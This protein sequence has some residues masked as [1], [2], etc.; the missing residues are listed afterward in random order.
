MPELLLELLSEEIPARMQARAAEDLKRLVCDGLKDA[1]LSFDHAESYVTPRR[2]ALVVDGIPEKLAAKSEEIRGP[3]A[4]APEK[5]VAGFKG[6]LPEGTIIVK[7]ET[8]K[9]E[10]FFALVEQKGK[11]TEYVLKDILGS[12]LN[13]FPWPKSMKWAEC[14]LPW[15]RPL[16][17]ALAIF[18][19][20]V[21]PFS[22]ALKSR[23][24][25]RAWGESENNL[26]DWENPLTAN[27]KTRGH[28]F[29]SPQSFKVKDFSDYKA[30]LEKAHVILDPAERRARIEAEAGKLAKAA[31]LT[32]MDDPALLAEVAGL[33]EWPVALMGSIDKA[34]MDL[35]DEVLTTSMRHH[36]K[37][38]A[39][40]DAKGKLAPKFIVVAN[41][42]ASDRGKA[43]VAGNERVLK[44]RL[45]DAKFFWDQDRKETL[46]SRAGALKDRVFHAKLGSVHDKVR[47]VEKL[48][49]AVAEYCGADANEA[50]RAARLAKA[51]LSTGMVAEFPELQGVMG[52]YYALNDG[53]APE[54]AAAIAEHYSPQGPGDA[55]PSAPVSIAVALAD[56]IDTLVG[57]WAIDEKPTGSKDPF[58][59][60]RAALGVIR[61]I[62][63]NGLRMGLITV[64]KNAHA[65][66]EDP[67]DKGAM[68][69][70][71]GPKTV[72]ENGSSFQLTE[73]YKI[74]SADV[75]GDT[76]LSFFADRLKVQM[77]EKGVRHDL[78]EAVFALGG[79]DDLVRLLAR[80]EALTV[81]LESDDG[82]DLLTAYKRAA[83]IVAI[84]EKK[85]KQSYDGEADPK[86]FA[87]GEETALHA[88][89][90]AAMEASSVALEGEDFTAVMAELAKLRAPVDAFFDEVTVNCD[91]PR[92]RENR[93]RLLSQIRATLG[94]V[95]D[96]SRIEG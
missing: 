38:F 26:Y 28:R 37:Y 29:L 24:G 25:K 18:Q 88:S 62:V 23:D 85:D 80:V 33:V 41:T 5:A 77:R 10:F 34:F 49:G 93:L 6:A 16:H 12:T 15:V 45:S 72:T 66:L 81:F 54:V 43:I 8:D 21:I 86:L 74:I 40:T 89:L 59:L 60:R 64:I 27:N 30:K 91:D 92:L 44:A 70:S 3:R 76:L 1:G 73:T 36:Q 84:E 20:K 2:L 58:A 19:G 83:N 9:G 95:A 48:A 56:K 61:L 14:D 55:C 69:V 32:L 46:E 94:N 67:I 65:L 22:I 39:L 42:E 50:K 96:F 90:G 53:E 82:A 79:E 17:N 52:R 31:K 63:E 35:P 87:Q 11:K 57:F 4:D 78:I 71:R 13:R 47:R 7:R 51:D 68:R 75:V